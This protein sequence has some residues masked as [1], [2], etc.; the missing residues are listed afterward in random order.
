MTD[1]EALMTIGLLVIESREAAGWTRAVA[2]ERIGLNYRTLQDVEKGKRLPNKT[3]LQGIEKTYGW[4]QGSLLRLWE[5]RKNVEFGATH[6]TDLRLSPAEIEVPLAKARELTT[7]EL[8]AE[9]S[10]RVLVMSRAEQKEDHP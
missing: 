5:D 3:T 9:I 2:A 7:E 4:S 1:E 6:H 10:F 8:I